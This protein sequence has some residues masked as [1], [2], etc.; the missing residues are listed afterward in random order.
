MFSSAHTK[1]TSRLDLSYKSHTLGIAKKIIVEQ[2]IDSYYMVLTKD[3]VQKRHCF[4]HFFLLLCRN[5]CLLINKLWCINDATSHS[6]E[7]VHSLRNRCD[8]FNPPFRTDVG[9]FPSAPVPWHCVSMCP[10]WERRERSKAWWTM[11]SDLPPQWVMFLLLSLMVWSSC[12][13]CW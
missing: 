7:G 9:G 2:P 6:H 13:A 11:E 12:M 8:S 10:R 1:S 4:L 3:C 5:G